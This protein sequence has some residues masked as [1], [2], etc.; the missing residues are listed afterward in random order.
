MPPAELVLHPVRLRIVQ[1]FVDDR[2]LTTGDLRCELP[3]VPVASLYRHVTALSAGGVLEVVGERK[4]RGAV[5]RT[6]R[7][8]DLSAGEPG[9]RVDD[10]SGGAERDRCSFAT[11]VAGLLGDFD[12]YLDDCKDDQRDGG[13]AA[14]DLAGYQ[15]VVLSL[16]DEELLAMLTE[17]REV[18]SRRIDL[19]PSP[20]RTTRLLTTV[21]LPTS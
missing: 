8:A 3:D 11:F 12:R 10:S 2:A 20:G 21:L 7:L 5:E 17:W 13:A 16:T 1:A 19:P 4:V 9:D 6:Y 15:Q 14:G 18:L